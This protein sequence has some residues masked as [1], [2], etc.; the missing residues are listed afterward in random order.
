MNDITTDLDDPP[1]FDAVIPLHPQSS[2]RI[3]YGGPDDAANQRAAHP[4]VQPIFTEMS[5]ADAFQRA[6]RV[7][8]DMGWNVVAES[9]THGIIEAVD[10]TPLFRFKDDIVVRVR[11]TAQGSRV[12][13]R[14]RSRIG[15]S[16][17]GKNAA[18]IMAYSAAFTPSN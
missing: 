9:A 17:L 6:L 13:L 2:N 5:S 3:E 11:A 14:S 10:T 4:E 8:N 1:V 16:D 7:A 12:D 15:L 18:R